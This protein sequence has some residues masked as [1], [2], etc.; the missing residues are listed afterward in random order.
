MTRP[1][2]FDARSRY[3]YYD[4]AV[5]GQRVTVALGGLVDPL[6]LSP[7]A[8]FD[9]SDISTLF[10][11]DGMT[12][13]VTAA[14]DPVGAV[15]DKSGNG[16]HLTQ[17][18]AGARPLYKTSGSLRW[19]EFDGS[20]DILSRTYGSALTQ[21]WDRLSAWRRITDIADNDFLFGG[22]I[23]IGSLY[24]RTSE[25]R[26]YSGTELTGLT[27][28][29]DAADFI[30]TERHNGASSRVAIDAGTYNSGDAGSTNQETLHVGSDVSGQVSNARFYG[31]II[32]D[33]ALTDDEID[34]LRAYLAA[35]Q[36]RS[37]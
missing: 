7:F 12:T 14:D 36:G 27:A 8:W 25:L 19:L 33:R 1:F 28:P 24:K 32:F 3:Y 9:P 20:N 22:N 10:Q 6:S 13:P 37:V 5:A 11:D 31:G 35:K 29:A 34:Q 18:T 16:H 30:A 15:L 17:S 2:P 26:I 4:A 21:P 23:S